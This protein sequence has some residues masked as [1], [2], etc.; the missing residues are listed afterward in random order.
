MNGN[1]SRWAANEARAHR[2][3]RRAERADVE[4]SLPA[5][6]R[7][8]QL[9]DLEA[10]TTKPH[11]VYRTGPTPAEHAAAA[12]AVRASMRS[13]GVVVLQTCDNGEQVLRN[14]LKTTRAPLHACVSGDTPLPPGVARVAGGGSALTFH[15]NDELSTR[16]GYPMES[17]CISAHGVLF[18]AGR[19]VLAALST[20]SPRK[21]RFLLA[22]GSRAPLLS[23]AE[24]SPP[25]YNR[26]ASPLA[27]VHHGGGGAAGSSGLSRHAD[28][29]GLLTIIH[30]PT[31]GLEVQL[32]RGGGAG[33][34]GK[35]AP[36]PCPRGCVLVLVGDAL[37]DATH[38]ALASPP[39]RVTSPSAALL[40]LRMVRADASPPPA[41][42]SPPAPSAASAAPRADSPAEAALRLPHVA[43]LVLGCL[44]ADDTSGRSVA[45]AEGV[46]RDLRAA[47][48]SAWPSLCVKFRAAVPTE[49]EALHARGSPSQWRRL[50]RFLTR[51]L[52]LKFKDQDNAEGACLRASWDTQRI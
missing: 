17:A 26:G 50:F 52:E 40:E 10:P 29:S 20:P 7:C 2:A 19:R 46:C 9:K 25:V 51:P 42:P 37:R 39:R 34:C 23:L 6:V 48:A 5:G 24:C 44:A 43:F 12:A 21:H 14:L 45:R 28:A 47:G 38:G 15:A 36:L 13:T 49:Y 31:P 11:S 3:L 41:A 8:I 33:G 35:W 22:D 4:A 16:L 30:S 32:L 27:V 18:R 1:V